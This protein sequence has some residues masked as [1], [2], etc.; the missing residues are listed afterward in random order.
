MA[1]LRYDLQFQA[2]FDLC[3]LQYWIVPCSSDLCLLQ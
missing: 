3:L 1:W 2:S